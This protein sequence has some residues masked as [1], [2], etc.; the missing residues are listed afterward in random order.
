AKLARKEAAG[1]FSHLK[2]KN[3][4]AVRVTALPQPTLPSVSVDN[5]EFDAYSTK[6]PYPSCHLYDNPVGGGQQNQYW[7]NSKS[8]YGAQ[9]NYA[10]STYAGTT[11][12]DQ[13]DYPPMQG[14]N[15]GY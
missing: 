2:N 12:G 11:A 7:S 13:D 3:S 15:N 8:A 1:D 6:Q 14:Y 5:E 9:S 10:P 4:E